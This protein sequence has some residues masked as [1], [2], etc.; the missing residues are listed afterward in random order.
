MLADGL[1]FGT[2]VSTI[3]LIEPLLGDVLKTE[4]LGSFGGS[5]A[6][7]LNF[8]LALRMDA[9]GAQLWQDNLTKAIGGPGEKFTTED[10]D[11]WRWNK[12]T[13]NS[14]WIVPARGWL[15]AGRG[16]ELLPLQVE[17]LQQV[18]QQGRPAP[19]LKDNW[20]EADLDWARLAAWLPD[21]SHLLKSCSIKISIKTQT[22]HL[23]T[24]AR[25]IYPE[26]IPWESTP[27]QIP[28]ELVRSPLVS[29]I[30]AQN[31]AAFLNLNP[32]FSQVG[33]SPFT[34]QFYVWALGEMPLQNYMA[35]PVA[36][37]TNAP[38]ASYPGQP[39]RPPHL[40]LN[41]KQFNRRF[42]IGLATGPEKTLYGE[43]GHGGRPI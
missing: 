24:T 3:A 11:G 22:N 30:A 6:N 29:F 19:A 25:V 42:R 23:L 28:T 15:I 35:W 18:K 21:W 37:A 34:N 40:M 16:D 26:V 2:N 17:Y 32:V 14:L 36:D 8:V 13:S 20:L 10:F 4:S 27:W 1:G 31:I 43:F 41:L 5:E 9:K 12:G 33:S 7:P 38:G 39:R